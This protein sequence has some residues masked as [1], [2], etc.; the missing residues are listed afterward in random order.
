[1]ESS[2]RFRA[3]RWL[4]ALLGFV[5]TL[6]TAG[7]APGR[8]NFIL[9]LADDLGATDLAC[10]GS[11]FYETP[12]IDR[13]AREGMRFTQ[14]Y[15]AC[16]VC[17]PTRAAVLTGRYPARLRVT[18]WIAGHQ[19]PNAKLRVP[20]WTKHLSLEEVTIA[21]RLRAVGYATASIGKWHLGGTD[22]RPERHGFDLNLAGTERGQP[23][24]YFSPYGIATLPD[25]PPGEFLTDRESI[26]ALRWIKGQGERPFFLYLPHH[27]VHTPL[28]GKTH[29]TEKYRA[30]AQPDAAQRNPT[31]AALVESLDDSI[32]RLQAGLEELGLNERTVIIF[33]SDNGGLLGNPRNP[34]TGNLGLRA[35]KGSAYEGG[36]R[37]PLI[38]KW[39][40][41]T[42]PGAICEV[43]VISVDLYPTLMEI[44]GLRSSKG[45]SLDGE[46]LT[47]LLR[48]GRKLSRTDLFWHYPHYHPG[49]ATPY[50]ALRWGDWKLIEF[51]EDSR[52]E[53]YHLRND[54][55]ET[56]D[57]AA[58]EPDRARMLRERLTK[59]RMRM[60][61]QLPTANPDYA[62][63]RAGEWSA[64]ALAPVAVG[65][66]R[67]PRVSTTAGSPSLGEMGR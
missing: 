4:A 41:V 28:M 66:S 57:C 64:A 50:S 44:A 40:G 14:A 42:R 30:R 52:V 58:R 27:A 47:K 32:G 3:V 60:D 9:I 2:L 38:V 12:N 48:G 46:S 53:L 31:Y 19:R 62:P 22:F 25:G 7:A 16:T 51:F 56:T 63:E 35:G 34:V 59:W 49:G 21:E 10:A 13:L 20:D 15:S 54:P 29:I 1:M 39:P 11:P 17:S 67:P 18:D 23:P 5:V 33:T 65:G 43:P 26:E 37:V 45:H 61:A 6:P 8:P 55:A 24:S 36:V